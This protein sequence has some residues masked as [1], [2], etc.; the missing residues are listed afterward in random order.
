MLES[1]ESIGNKA[2]K[3]ALTIK[4]KKQDKIPPTNN[5]TNNF[6]G[7]LF[8]SFLYINIPKR[9]TGN[10]EIVNNI[11]SATIYTLIKL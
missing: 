6:Q 2:P 11:N 9:K 7:S 10:D 5:F 1:A 3:I 4:T 8:L